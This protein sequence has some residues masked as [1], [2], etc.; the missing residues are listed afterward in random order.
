[1]IEVNWIDL[2]IYLNYN[3][4]SRRIYKELLNLYLPAQ[5]NDYSWEGRRG[6]SYMNIYVFFFSHQLKK[7]QIFTWTFS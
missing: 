7:K 1:M 2:K 6:S 3:F 5:R 4:L